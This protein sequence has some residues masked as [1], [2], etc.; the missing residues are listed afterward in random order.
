[1]A[2]ARSRG[3]LLASVLLLALPSCRPEEAGQAEAADGPLDIF[4]SI[5]PQ[6]AFVEAIGGQRVRVH[7]MVGPGASPATYE[8]TPKQMAKL[9]EARLYFRVGVGFE[10]AWMHRLKRA[11]PDLDVVDTRRPIEL[12]PIEAHVHDGEGEFHDEGR[13]DPHFWTSPAR[14]KRSATTIRDALADLDPG[15]AEGYAERYEAFAADVARLDADIRQ[16]LN[17]LQGRRFMVFHPAWGY[18]AEDYGLEQ[19]PIEIRGKEPGPRSLAR[20]VDEGRRD[21]IPVIFVQRQF[22]AGTARTVAEAIGAEVID[23]DPLAA[24]W[25]DNLRRVAE[26]FA[27]ALR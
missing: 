17:G 24:D 18:F 20:L 5:L 19:V 11:N 6:K 16:T 25:A 7:V 1:M 21:G 27:E 2:R 8:P 13:E 10:D 4:V 15:H 14:V 23:V 12:R 3:L 26:A 22:A 9:S